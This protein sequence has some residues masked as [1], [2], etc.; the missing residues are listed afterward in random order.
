M[1]NE[2]Q[3]WFKI[4]SQPIRQSLFNEKISKFIFNEA[5]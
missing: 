2:R 5:I 1:L 3:M 4:D